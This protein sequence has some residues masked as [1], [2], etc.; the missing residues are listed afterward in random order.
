ME[1]YTP[2]TY[3]KRVAC[4]PKTGPNFMF[5]SERKIFRRRQVNGPKKVHTGTDHHKTHGNSKFKK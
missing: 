4:P 3:N 5:G 1:Q 2:P